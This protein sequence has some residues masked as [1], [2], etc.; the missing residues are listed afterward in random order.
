MEELSAS[1]KDHFTLAVATISVMI[2]AISWRRWKSSSS[3]GAPSLPPGPRSLPIVGYLPFLRRDLHKQFRNMAHIYGPIFKFHLGSKLHVVINTPDLVKAVVREQDDIFSNRNPS[4]AALAIS[5]GGRNV[6]FSDNNSDWRNLRKIFAHEVLSNKNLEACRFFRRDEVRKTIKNIY[7][8]I[9]TTIDISEIAFSTEANV[10]TSMVWENTSD[11]NAKGSQFGA[12]LKRISSNIVELLGQPNLSDIFPSVAWLDLQG[13]LRKMK[14]QL[15]QLDEIFTTIIEDRIISNSKK[16][17][18]AGG[19]EGKKDLLQIL[20]ELMDQKDAASISITQIKALLLDIMVAGSETT[21][22]LIEWAMAEI[23]QNDDIM[24][25]V[26]QELEEIVGLDNIVEESHLPKLQYLDA[27]IKET[28]RLHPVVPL[29]LPRSPSQ[30]CIVGGYT[31]PKGCTVLLNVWSIHRDHR[32]W[33]NPLIFNPE[34]FLTNK[35]DFKG[36]NLNLICY[37]KDG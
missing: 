14:R 22:T 26:Q 31:I 23:M 35:Y 34:R 29:I 36:G 30:D 19:H 25:K 10:L 37:D 33:D 7:S 2:F 1:N 12:E 5:Y 24:K 28:F 9:G 17:K 27:I 3:S 13:I 6:V 20:L 16:P 15:H 18:D 8:K 21:T 11:P 32:Y 4:I